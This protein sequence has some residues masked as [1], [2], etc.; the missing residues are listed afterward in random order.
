VLAT[1]VTFDADRRVLTATP[2][3]SPQIS[4]SWDGVFTIGEK[5]M[6]FDHEQPQPELTLDSNKSAA[7]NAHQLF[8]S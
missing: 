3:G 8:Y 5:A 4:L 6:A 1:E 7:S 2:P